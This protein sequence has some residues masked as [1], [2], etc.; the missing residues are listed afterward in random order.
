MYS[1]FTQAARIALHHTLDEGQL[2]YQDTGFHGWDLDGS[3]SVMFRPPEHFLHQTGLKRFQLLPQ[4]LCHYLVFTPIHQDR[5]YT[6]LQ[7]R[8]GRKGTDVTLEDIN[9]ARM[10]EGTSSF[11]DVLINGLRI[12]NRAFW[13][14]SSTDFVSRRS[15]LHQNPKHFATSPTGIIDPS[16][17]HVRSATFR[18]LEKSTISH[19]LKFNLSRFS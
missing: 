7:H 15:P 14:L 4:T 9:A 6:V 5:H 18:S 16:T 13:M 3:V 11:L 12:Q 2:S 17:T 10:E 1:L 8:P 19:F